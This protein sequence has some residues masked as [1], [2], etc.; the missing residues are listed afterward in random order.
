[1]H[2]K[3]STAVVI[4]FGPFL[5]PS[6]GVTLV[7]SLVSAIDHASTGIFLSKNGGALT[8]R[9]AAVTASTYDA[10]GNYLVTLDTTDTNTLGTLRVQFAA[11]ASCLPVW[12][13]FMILPANVWDSLYGSDA[14]QVDL[15]QILGTAV[16]TPATAGIL[17]VNLKNIANATV[18]ASTAQLGVNVVNFGGS[19][20]TFASGRPEVNT[21]HIAGAA[22]STT[23]AQIGVNIVQ[24]STDAVAADNA[25][26]FF[27]GTGY[28]H[29]L[30]RTTIATLASQTSF[31]LTAGSADNDAYNDCIIV[32]EDASTAAQKAVAVVDDYTGST[33]TITLRTDP[34][35][36]TMATTDIVTIIADRALKPT[37]MNRTLDVSSGGEAGL[38]WANVGTQGATV[39]LSATTVN[40]VNTITTYTGNTVQ[41]GDAFAR[42]GAPVGASISADVA[43]VQSDTNDIQ[44]RIPAAL[45]AGGN[46][47]AD[48]LALS[49][50]TVAADNAESFFDGTG[51]AGTNNVIPTVTLV[52][53]LTTYTG[54]TVQTGDSFARI[55]ANGVGLT[56]VALVSTGLDAIA[57]TAPSGVASTFPGMV[58]QLWRRMFKKSTLT[59]TQLKTYADDGTTVVTTQTVSDDTVTQTQGAAS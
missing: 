30:Q 32:I 54:N 16:S 23:T 12:Q 36:F 8:I 52:N 45:T 14:L 13:D 11:A 49:G 48:A 27:D 10:Y 21:T 24:I 5:N 3:Q 9:H 58:V 43:G 29:I 37:V 51:Y 35:V 22:V 33:K 1:M 26:A 17:D 59:S 34:A 31:T 18:S 53:T 20:G 57:T 56:S 38:D 6:D 39:N 4:S 40:L 47:K 44:T 25:E 55:G 7:T 2:L 50:D 28:G 46:M 41:T 19:A 42:L 15:I